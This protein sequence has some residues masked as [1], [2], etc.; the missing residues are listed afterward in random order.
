[1]A[2]RGRSGYGPYGERARKTGSNPVIE[3][4]LTIGAL[5]IFPLRLLGVI[6]AGLFGGVFEGITDKI[7]MSV[8]KK[9]TES[10]AK[11]PKGE[12]K[13]SEKKSEQA[14]VPKEGGPYKVVTTTYYTNQPSDSED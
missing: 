6:I 7:D 11:K 10:P 4:L 3:S 9:E 13:D 5:L 1:M 14:P 8:P 12:K 2:I